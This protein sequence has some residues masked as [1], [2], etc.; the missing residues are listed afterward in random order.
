MPTANGC[1]WGSNLREVWART[2]R[3]TGEI[4]H[5]SGKKDGMQNQQEIKL[6]SHVRFQVSD[7]WPLPRLGLDS[8][9]RLRSAQPLRHLKKRHLKISLCV[10]VCVSFIWGSK[11]SSSVCLYVWASGNQ[12][13]EAKTYRYTVSIPKFIISLFYVHSLLWLR[14]SSNNVQSLLSLFWCFIVWTC[15]FPMTDM[16]LLTVLIVLIVWVWNGPKIQG[17]SSLFPPDC[18]ILEGSS[19]LRT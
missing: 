13:G 18:T 11:D 16:R 19:N 17:L 12:N 14:C 1:V 8:R 3:G 15:S 9:E 4:H 2:Q 5:N 10:Y 7:H 6:T